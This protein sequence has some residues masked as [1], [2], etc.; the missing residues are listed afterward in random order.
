MRLSLRTLSL[1]SCAAVLLGA[2]TANAQ[3]FGTVYTDIGYDTGGQGSGYAINGVSLADLSAAIASASGP[4]YSFISNEV[5]FYAPGHAGTA[6]PTVSNT[7]AYFLGSQGASVIGSAVT[8][9]AL[10]TGNLI[11]LNGAVSLTNGQTYTLMHDDGVNLYITGNG[12]SNENIYS[13]QGQTTASPSQ[14][15]TFD[16]TTG[17]YY[18]ELLYVSNYEAPSELEAS[19]ALLRTFGNPTPEPSSFILLGTGLLGAAGAIR[20]KLMA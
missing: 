15:F 1:V 20:R 2:G 4:S 14:T 8:S 5:D 12:V 9:G 6:L 7:L 17:T 18:A 19:G 10:A 13:D 16:G 11:V 3:V